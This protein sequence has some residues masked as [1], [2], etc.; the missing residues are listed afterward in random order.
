MG[1]DTRRQ[2]S[3]TGSYDLTTADEA[4]EVERLKQRSD[5]AKQEALW[6]RAGLTPGMKAID[7]G[8][9]P[10]VF[11]AALARMVGT[12]EVLGVD[13]SQAMIDL[14]EIA[15][16]S[17][18]L[19]NLRF[20]RASAD[21][22]AVPRHH[23]DF[24]WA[25]YLFQHTEDAGGL[26][27]SLARMLRPGGIACLVD[28]DREFVRFF[29][30]PDGWAAFAELANQGQRRRGGDPF[31]GRKLATYL[32]DAGFEDIR[33]EL[34]WDV[35]RG[36]EIDWFCDNVAQSLIDL[37]LPPES[38]GMADR[39]RE[40]LHLAARDGRTFLYHAV[41]VVIATSGRGA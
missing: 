13:A 18:G 25:R 33:A 6:R 3:E 41:F 29:P 36:S 38:G 21:A 28:A 30:E 1:N 11:S 9:G 19:D 8:C 40:A 32:A 2:S 17:A 34:V 10:G 22:E 27:R 12:G 5:T 39:I 20:L 4:S 23:F 26:A 31:V 35:L 15:A 24:A 14:A 37:Y 7:L 16:R